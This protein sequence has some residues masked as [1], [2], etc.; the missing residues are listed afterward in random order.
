MSKILNQLYAQPSLPVFQ[1]RMYDSREQAVNCPT[2]DVSLVQNL[3]TGLIYNQAFQPNLLVY[4][5]AYQNE[6]GFSR[7]FQDHMREVIGIVDR[8]M[9]RQNLVEVGCGKGTFLEMLLSAGFDVAGFD[10]TYEGNNSRIRRHL[11]QKGVG[12]QARGLTLRHVLEHIP[13]PVAF[14]KDL[15][16]A[17]HG[18]GRI[19]IEVPCFDWICNRRTWFDVFY[20]HVNYFRIADFHRIFE[21]VVESGRLF[22]GQYLYVVAELSSVRDPKI[23]SVE[24]PFAFPCDFTSGI[25]SEKYNTNR[26]AIVWGGASKGVIFSLL[27]SRAGYPVDAVIDISPSKQG[28]FLGVTG[29]RVESPEEVLPRLLPGDPIFV[30]NSNYLEEIKSIT[31][32]RFTYILT[33]H[34]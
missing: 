21:R 16:E 6:Q 17:N 4:D 3:H 20:E 18:A 25:H 14:L 10:P 9:G 29:L 31:Q 1:N 11:F 23:E 26:P 34:E 7:H 33:D 5:A 8:G 22:G 32:N 19:Y 27:R 13:E 24:D 12:I 28:K 30:M 15:A 2:G